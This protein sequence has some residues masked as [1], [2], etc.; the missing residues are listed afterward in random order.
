MMREFYRRWHNFFVT[1]SIVA[2]STAFVAMLPSEPN[3]WITRALTL[4]VSL[5]AV[6]DLVFDLQRKGDVHDQLCR[7]FSELSARMT[8]WPATLENEAKACAERTLIEADEPSVVRLIDLRAHN[9]E[10]QA[11]GVPF[12]QLVPLD[13][14]QDS[15]WGYYGTFGLH[16]LRKR[17]EANER[18]AASL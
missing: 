14:F 12:D 17:M 10:L 16:D 2:G 4:A 9:E 13:R 7:R 1:I 6:I 11:Q 8:L 18:T 15:F 3:L 5:A